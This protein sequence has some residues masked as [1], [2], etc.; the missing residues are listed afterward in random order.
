M[1]YVECINARLALNRRITNNHK[2]K[3]AL[4]INQGDLTS[5][6]S[7]LQ[8]LLHYSP[9]NGATDN[10]SIRVMANCLDNASAHWFIF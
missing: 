7:K 4:E 1:P 2:L 8:C 10:G 3:S 9:L 6:I 5:F